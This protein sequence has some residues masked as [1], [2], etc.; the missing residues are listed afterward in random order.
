MNAL[1]GQKAKANFSLFLALS[2]LTA[3]DD[4]RKDR[5]DFAGACAGRHLGRGFEF[6]VLHDGSGEL[7]P[8]KW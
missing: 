3:D 4:S 7:Q 5:R 1:V 8:S 6:D 2:K